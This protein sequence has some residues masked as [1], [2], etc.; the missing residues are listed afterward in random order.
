MKKIAS[1]LIMILMVILI[2]M[3]TTVMAQ[4]APK[5]P[6]A[7]DAT[8]TFTILH[9]NDF[10][11]Q[12]EA[13]GSN[14]G[15][16][17]V[18]KVINDVRTA[19]GAAK[20]LVIDAG[21][22][23]Q[24]SLLSNLQKGEPTIA[25]FNQIGYDA[26]TFG[27]HEF[28]WGQTVL[29]D[30]VTQATH[31]YLAANLAVKTGPDCSSAGWTK[32]AFVDNPYIIK[33]ITDGVNSVKVGII[34][35]TSQETP[36]I[37]IASATEGVCFKD[38][39]ESII[40]YYDEMKTNGA[41]IIVVVSH[42]GYTDGGYGYGVQV[43]G[44]QT[45]ATKLNTAGKP[46]NLI[47]GGHSHTNLATATTVGTTKIVQAHYNG[48][49]VGRADVSYDTGTQA[50]TINWAPIAVPTSG[51]G[52]PAM[53]TLVTSYS[54][55]PAYQAKITQVVGWSNIDMVRDYNGESTISNMVQDAVYGFMNQTP[56]T[57]VDMVFNNAGGIRADIVGANHPF[58][59]TYGA[60][61]NVLP[62]GNQ[63]IR[64]DMTGA[65]IEEL[66]NQSAT[67]FKGALQVAGL[68]YKFY[69][70]QK[71]HPV[72]GSNTIWAW[73]AFDIMVWNKTTLAWEPLEINKTYKI[74]TNEFL[75]PAGQDGFT[76]FKK[77]TNITYHGDMLDQVNDWLTTNH[78]TEAT[79]YDAA[80]DGRIVRDGNDAGGSIVPL[81]I[82]HHNDSHGRLL[83]S[84]SYPGLT[85]LAT[86][87]KAERQLNPDRTL[88]LNAGDVIQGD[89]MMYYYRTAPSGFAANGDPLPVALQTHPLIAAFNDLNY[90]A[91]TLGNHE[92][93]FGGTVFSGI[94]SQAAFPVLQANIS[95]DG[96]YGLAAGNVEPSVVKTVGAENITVAIL[97]IGN[98]RVPNYELPSN[99]AGLH[100][101]NP[102]TTAESLAPGLKAANDVVIALTHIG[103]TTNPNSSEV[104]ENV[105][106]NLAAQVTGIDAIVG[107][108]S[109]TS[110][111]PGL[112]YSAPSPYLWLPTFVG[113]P[114]N[115]PV[116][117]GQANR[118]NDTLGEI[119][120]GL[121]AKS[122]GGYEVVARAGKYVS[123]TTAIAQDPAIKDII[124]PYQTQ[125][126]AYNAQV[127][128][129]TT[130]PID[131]N[132]AFTAETNGANMQ[133]DAS[134]F[135]L[136]KNNIYPDFHLS[137]A[138]TNKLVAATATI[139]NPV[140]MTIA[141]LFSAMPYENSLV[142]MSLNGPQLKRILERAYRNYF[143][144]KY[145]PGW[146][147]YSHYTT[148]MLDINS[149]GNIK[150]SETTPAYPDGNNVISLTFDDGAKSVD[151][152]DADTYYLV[153][154]V[155][156][157][158]AGSCNFN[159]GGV[160]LWPVD[161][162]VNDTQYYVRDA[163]ID[164]MQDQGTVSPAI[165]GR[166]TF[167]TP[168]NVSL[169]PVTGGVFKYVGT[170]TKE[171]SFSVPNQT[172]SGPTTL[173]YTMLP[174][175]TFGSF[176]F[177]GDAFNLVAYG[178][179]NKPISTLA[180][181]ITVF[182]Q[183]R[184]ADIVGLDEMSLRLDYWN[185]TAWV[186]AACGTY[187]RMPS[188][189]YFSVPIC[190]LS[191][192]VVTGSKMYFLPQMFK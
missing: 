187:T 160:S 152:G 84:G 185:G 158:A 40:H 128:G 106:T 78:G 110:P 154:T 166:L 44:D 57:E 12:L 108:H 3:P 70:Y 134:M 94:F 132:A 60:T 130:V 192:F 41:K 9:T 80:L 90:D 104:D 148:C 69:R 45:L 76:P 126:A 99:I 114:D 179:D 66:L 138:M 25:A 92:F 72:G 174:E 189:N 33:T 137:G 62:F 63:T 191:R 131:T 23:M 85:N 11:G 14:P 21:D 6:Q 170:N 144:Y 151:F 51:A 113:S 38:P 87:I 67:L 48:R 176:F 19:V 150:Y 186:D 153:S 181:P 34:G 16:S 91:M 117:I 143:F 42:I 100:F 7:P 61:F 156:Y 36:Y 145:V 65:A 107:G 159:D 133:A 2:A 1:H 122:G 183:Y 98:H 96:A 26:A 178:A 17:R 141:D 83:P 43:Y 37:T 47:I 97:G 95:D 31:P 167:V 124:D 111:A 147:G 55:D 89:A 139:T 146:G 20:V 22:E 190:H 168:T 115:T 171:I 82:L 54:S 162:I 8:L 184:D 140:Q 177:A 81:T 79:A 10:H 142:T 127:V 175:P 182:V 77:V 5:A 149:G 56:A 24:G 75:A 68:K 32:P 118:Y 29:Q 28:D 123:V 64:G 129:S 15:I 180:R 169:A 161:Q 46:V 73:G 116:I 27:N 35:V 53:D 103:F 71:P 50:V 52:D 172:F 86:V 105:D 157:L 125:F 136:N 173:A 49:R 30:R 112:S 135:E 74:A 164:Y 102:I 101:L 39:A 93:N 109:H 155:N 165:E 59:V 163:V 119:V 4:G 13:A 88:L 121:R 58:A 18:S 188:I 120:L